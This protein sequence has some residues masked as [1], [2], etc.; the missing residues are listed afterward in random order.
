MIFKFSEILH[1]IYKHIYN[2]DSNFTY[3]DFLRLIQLYDKLSKKSLNGDLVKLLLIYDRLSEEEKNEVAVMISILTIAEMDGSDVT[4][5]MPVE[6][7]SLYWKYI[8]QIFSQ[9][10]NLEGE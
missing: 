7:W 3:E 8:R 1:N 9:N 10:T 2:S 5:E 4:K 6:L